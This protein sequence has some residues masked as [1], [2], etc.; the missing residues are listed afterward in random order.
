VAVPV[1]SALV[2]SA[3]VL[4]SA[5]PCWGLQ[6][7][8]RT[9]GDDMQWAVKV[10]LIHA[11]CL[12]LIWGQPYT[13]SIDSVL[14]FMGLIVPLYVIF[15]LIRPLVLT[16]RAY[17]TL[18]ALAGVMTIFGVMMVRFVPEWGNNHA[19]HRLATFF[20]GAI[21]GVAY[22]RH[23]SI[24]TLFRQP[25]LCLGLF[26]AAAMPIYFGYLAFLLYLVAG[27]MIAFLGI[28]LAG[29][30]GDGASRTGFVL[31]PIYFAAVAIGFIGYELYLYHQYLIVT[32]GL[33][34]LTPWLSARWPSLG[35]IDAAVVSTIC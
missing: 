3:G 14:W 9:Y 24:D 5:A 33:T 19:P 34:W 12:H 11:S 23:D 10:L 2:H 21:V 13:H 32:V 18:G 15:A 27:L 25:L 4:G 7:L 22:R 20:I 17:A 8:R 26:F 6:L 31:R 16:D 35:A 1:A 28:A 30:G 29:V